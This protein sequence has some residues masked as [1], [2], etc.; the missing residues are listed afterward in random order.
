M[1]VL[2]GA[3]KQ[4]R[5]SIGQAGLDLEDEVSVPLSGRNKSHVKAQHSLLEV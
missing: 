4:P 1:V 5:A 2:P 3:F